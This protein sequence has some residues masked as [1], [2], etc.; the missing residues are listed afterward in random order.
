MS[1]L[2]SKLMWF[3]KNKHVHAI[4]SCLIEFQVAKCM[5]DLHN[6]CHYECNATCTQH[7]RQCELVFNHGV[8]GLT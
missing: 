6:N 4:Q 5:Y 7:H 8:K 3:H 2:A 1:S